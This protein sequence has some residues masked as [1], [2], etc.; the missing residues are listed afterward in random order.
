MNYV[1]STMSDSV[2]YVQYG[3][4]AD[5]TPLPQK[6]VTINGGAN[7]QDKHLFTPE[8]VITSVT[9][10][11]LKILEAHPVFNKH[12]QGGYVKVTKQNKLAISDMEKKDEASQLVEEDFTKKGKKAPKVNKKA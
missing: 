12:K 10:E 6:S 1:I 9:D 11:E 8:G 3:K 7:V 2:T 4:S 5:G